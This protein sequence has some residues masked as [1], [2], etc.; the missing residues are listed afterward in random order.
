MYYFYEVCDTFEEFKEFFINSGLDFENSYM[1]NFYNFLRSSFRNR[2]FRWDDIEEIRMLCV[3]HLLDAFFIYK[4]LASAYNYNVDQLTETSTTGRIYGLPG[5]E[6]SISQ[7]NIDKYLT[8]KTHYSST[9]SKVDNLFK[10][11][12]FNDFYISV[13][14]ELAKMFSTF[15]PLI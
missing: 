9:P 4:N 7:E 10:L 14:K 8:G 11:E 13:R 3:I 2:L 12:R 6:S 5:D 1:K 15:N